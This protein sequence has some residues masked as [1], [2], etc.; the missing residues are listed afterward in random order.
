LSLNELMGLGFL[1]QSQTLVQLEQEEPVFSDIPD[2]D[3]A[4]TQPQEVETVAASDHPVGSGTTE[5]PSERQ[6]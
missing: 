3:E 2:R 6:E 1:A 5:P 4:P